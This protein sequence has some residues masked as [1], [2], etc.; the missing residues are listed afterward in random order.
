[1]EIPDSDVEDYAKANGSAATADDEP[2]DKKLKR[3]L[4]CPVCDKIPTIL[5]IPTC[6]KGHIVCRDCKDKIPI[7]RQTGR[8][9]CPICRSP[10]D[11]NTN[12]VVGSVISLLS[13]I[14]C[15]F[16]D[17]GCSFEGNIED[18]K[19]HEHVCKFRMV[20]C[21]MCLEECMRKDFLSHNNKNCFLTSPDNT[22]NFQCTY[23]TYIYLVQ[24]N[25]EEELLEVFVEAYYD[26]MGVGDINYVG[27]NLFLF[28]SGNEETMTNSSKIKITMKIPEDPLFH[29][30]AMV[31]LDA[32]TYYLDKW[33][34]DL[35]LAARNGDSEITLEIIKQ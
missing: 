29:I 30:E 14:P 32:G 19:A 18:H 26:R 25:T 11:E 15:S 1:M 17:S 33:D 24:V 31:D 27:F 9:P 20:K 10:L 5:P 8:I 7:N 6:S 28:S 22:F 3:E 34:A 21:F 35:I 23:D 2:L 4:Q 12:H 13:D 16:K